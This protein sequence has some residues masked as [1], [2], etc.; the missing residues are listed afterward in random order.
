MK[1]TTARRALPS[2]NSP[3]ISATQDAIEQMRQDIKEFEFNQT[4]D[5][6]AWRRT[7]PAPLNTL[8]NYPA[9]R[10]LL[11]SRATSQFWLV[12]SAI[13]GV[14]FIV[15]DSRRNLTSA[16]ILVIK[17]DFPDL[18]N[19]IDPQLIP[20]Y[21]LAVTG[22]Q[23]LI[24]DNVEPRKINNVDPDVVA[25]LR[26]PPGIQSMYYYIYIF[27]PEPLQD[28]EQGQ[29]GTIRREIRDLVEF[30]MPTGREISEVVNIF[31]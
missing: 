16:E 1:E 6:D 17:N 3:V 22:T 9:L 4:L 20:G 18:I 13:Y 7:L 8:G 30:F 15:S 10:S 29:I 27:F 2:Y 23:S 31:R 14:P 21:I 24:I 11:R 28:Y 25:N 5:T 26:P 19:N 12:V